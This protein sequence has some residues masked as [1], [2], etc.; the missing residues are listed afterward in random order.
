MVNM[1]TNVSVDDV[2]YNQVF[3]ELL[4]LSCLSVM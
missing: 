1:A 2:L 3:V 4:S